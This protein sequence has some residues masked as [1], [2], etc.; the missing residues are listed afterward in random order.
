MT[1][2]ATVLSPVFDDLLDALR[3]VA[4]AIASEHLPSLRQNGDS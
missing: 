1:R 2:D 3:I 4:R